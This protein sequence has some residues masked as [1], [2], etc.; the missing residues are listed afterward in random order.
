[1]VGVHPLLACVQKTTNPYLIYTLHTT[2]AR[3][4]LIQ[5]GVSVSYC[6]GLR[7]TY[8]HVSMDN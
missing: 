8:V 3:T 5:G 1:M 4:E 7:M 6:A 2:Q